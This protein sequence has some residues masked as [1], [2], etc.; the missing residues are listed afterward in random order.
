MQEQRMD[1]AAAI[2]LPS[3]LDYLVEHNLI[4]ADEQ[5]ASAPDAT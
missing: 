4:P 2:T 5:A 1:E 3:V